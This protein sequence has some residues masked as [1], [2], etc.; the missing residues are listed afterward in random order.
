MRAGMWS[1]GCAIVGSHDF[2]FVMAAVDDFDAWYSGLHPRLV[3][4]L[5]GVVGDV[6]V[7]RDAADE[8]LV[9]ALEKWSSVSEMSSPDGWTYR[10][11]LNVARRRLRRRALER[12]LLR[13]LDVAAVVPGPSGE[14]WLLVA[15]L[16][17]RQREAV[18]LRHVAGLTEPEVAEAM[19]VS[20]GTVNS[21]LRAAHGRLRAAVSADSFAGIAGEESHG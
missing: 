4:V 18:L 1:G 7:A 14:V 3:T 10:V 13:R 21:T 8:A 20:R 5:V 2:G 6:D 19:G 11:A 9:R 15:D 16:G 17:V 12:R